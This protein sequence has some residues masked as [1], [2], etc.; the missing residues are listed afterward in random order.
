MPTYLKRPSP[1]TNPNATVVAEI[2][3]TRVPLPLLASPGRPPTVGPAFEPV[4]KGAPLECT[5]R[6]QRAIGLASWHIPDNVG[7][8]P[9][10]LA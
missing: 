1:T 5:L 7:V 10:G 9:P 4:G 3:I 2:S 6:V 8:A